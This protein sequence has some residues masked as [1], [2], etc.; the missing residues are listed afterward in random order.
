MLVLKLYVLTAILASV[1]VGS[2][3]VLQKRGLDEIPSIDSDWFLEGYKLNLDNVKKSLPFLVNRYFLLG[4]FLSFFGGLL[5]LRAIS[6]GNLV[7]V[8]P[9]QSIGSFVAVLLG[10]L[11]LNENLERNEYIGIILVILGLIF[12]SL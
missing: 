7:I 8:Q 3:G 4:I 9:L 2:G 11:W 6:I 1:L 10:V 12:L 5:H